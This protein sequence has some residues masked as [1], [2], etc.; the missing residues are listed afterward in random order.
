[1]PTTAAQLRIRYLYHYQRYGAEAATRLEM[2]LR[3]NRLYM[4]SPGQFN[5]PWD[6][7]SWFD[8]DALE[9]QAGR[10]AHI[11]WFMRLPQARA[12]DAEDPRRHSSCRL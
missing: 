3:T 2:M 1:M 4:S 11:A 7:R 8:L 12:A 9:T 10:E 5:D 6:C